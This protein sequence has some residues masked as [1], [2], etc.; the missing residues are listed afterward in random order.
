[1]FFVILQLICTNVYH[2][3]SCSNIDHTVRIQLE[4]AFEGGATS[5]VLSPAL[6]DEAQSRIYDLMRNDLWLR[7]MQSAVYS[8]HEDEIESP[9]VAEDNKVRTFTCFVTSSH[10]YIVTAEKQIF[11]SI[12]SWP[13]SKRSKRRLSQ[14]ASRL[15]AIARRLSRQQTCRHVEHTFDVIL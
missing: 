1:M 5:D 6:F 9:A 8:Q 13:Q 3:C 7:F 10:V 12:V 4:A 11:E 14:S 15:G 2:F